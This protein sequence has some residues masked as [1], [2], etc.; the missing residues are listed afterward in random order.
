MGLTLREVVR[1]EG[2]TLH[3]PLTGFSCSADDV[4]ALLLLGFF[5]GTCERSRTRL[6]R[7]PDAPRVSA[8]EGT[9][10]AC[11]LSGECC[12]GYVFGPVGEAEKARIEALHPRDAL[13]YL[14]DEPLFVPGPTAYRLATK[15]DVCVFRDEA[16]RCGLHRAFGPSAKPRLCRLFPLAL[17]RTI[18]GLKIY[19][20]AEC[21]TF[22]VSSRHGPSSEQ[23]VASIEDLADEPLYHPV[24]HV[25][26]SLRCDYGL[27]LALSRRLD[28]EA[29]ESRP[30]DALQRI[31]HIAR[32]FAVALHSC[33]LRSGEPE[34]S[35]DTLL[36]RTAAE[37]R[38]PDDVVAA[39]A[40]NGLRNIAALCGAL[41]ERV[42]PS[43]PFTAPFVEAA[44]ALGEA[45]RDGT[46]RRRP[47]DPAV[48]AALTWSL[49]QQL[50]GRD[51]LLDESLPA[52]LLR[53]ALVV[54]LTH[55]VRNGTASLTRLSAR[56]MAVKRTLHRPEPAR[57]LAA[58]EDKAW[59]VLDALPLLT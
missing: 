9:R 30:L 58:N 39:S 24:V 32:A 35:V 52:G 20:R 31:G 3:D 47:L 1:V 37:L 10:F 34:A 25:Y 43:E 51:L 17:L 12:R 7:P 22:A 29:R 44:S 59:S 45:C 50:F 27:V 36:A 55:A 16:N 42:A 23:L 15:G 53:I 5:E 38:P 2:R 21:A 18:D 14:G 56:H 4:R 33:P 26:R 13:P 48:D 19:D 8:L 46:E 57:L 41:A 40:A 11:G 49:R 28:D 54:A 6:E